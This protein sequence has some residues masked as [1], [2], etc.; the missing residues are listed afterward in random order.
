MRKDSW[1]KSMLASDLAVNLPTSVERVPVQG[2]SVPPF[3]EPIHRC[4]GREAVTIDPPRD[5]HGR[6]VYVS[7]VCAAMASKKSFH[8]R[9]HAW[10]KRSIS[11]VLAVRV[12]YALNA[13]Q[14]WR[15][16]APNAAEQDAAARE[17]LADFDALSET[18]R[19]A[20]E[21][22][23][24]DAA[25]PAMVWC[26]LQHKKGQLEAL[27]RG[28]HGVII[29]SPKACPALLRA[30]RDMGPHA[31][32]DNFYVEEVKA[33]SQMC[34]TKILPDMT[35]IDAL[36]SLCTERS[37][38][39]FS[40]CADWLFD[41][42]PACVMQHLVRD[43]P[44]LVFHVSD[45]R[46]HM[47]R[48]VA[49]FYG[50]GLEEAE[51]AE[52]GQPAFDAHYNRL[53]ACCLTHRDFDVW[54]H[55]NYGKA[56]VRM[57]A[58]AVELGINAVLVIGT[59][60]DDDK[61]RFL[62]DF[63]RECA[64]A[65]IVF[66]T[67][68]ITVGV[69]F[70]RNF[71]ACVVVEGTG[72]SGPLEAAQSS[73]RAARADVPECNF[74]LWCI[75]NAGPPKPDEK[76]TSLAAARK[77][78]ECKRV[79]KARFASR[80]SFTSEVV[81]PL[82]LEVKAV[83]EAYDID[84][85]SHCALLVQKLIEY[86]PGWTLVDP[87]AIVLPPRLAALSDADVSAALEAAKPLP[88]DQIQKVD[89]LTPEQ[90]MRLGYGE[91][92][93]MATEA[94]EGG[95][96]ESYAAAEKDVLDTCGGMFAHAH[97]SGTFQ[98]GKALSGVD[99]QTVQSWRA[100]RHF[101]SLAA[102]TPKQLL[103]VEK[104]ED[105][106]NLAACHL[107]LG[108][109]R[110]LL[111]RSL[112]KSAAADSVKV[113]L[114]TRL[115]ER[116]DALEQ[117]ST[118]IGVTCL[119]IES[120]V[121]TADAP[122]VRLLQLDKM[123]VADAEISSTRKRL[124]VLADTVAGDSSVGSTKD[125]WTTLNSLLALICAEAVVIKDR[126][127]T[128]A[129]QADWVKRNECEGGGFLASKC[130][131]TAAAT[132]ADA[133]LR[134]ILGEPSEDGSEAPTE[135]TETANDAAA[136]GVSDGASV[137]KRR[138]TVP[139][140]KPQS[141]LAREGTNLRVPVEVEL[142]RRVFYF[143]A[144]G[145]VLDPRKARCVKDGEYR[146]ANQ[147]AGEATSEALKVTPVDFVAD[148]RVF[149]A[150]L[151]ESITTRALL[152]KQMP[153][154]TVEQE[155]AAL[156]PATEPP[157][158]VT[159]E[160]KVVFAAAA[161][162]QGIK[163][164]LRVTEKDG[165]RY[166]NEPIP[167]AAFAK[168]L[169]QLREEKARHGNRLCSPQLL[170]DFKKASRGERLRLEREHEAKAQG[171][172]GPK[173]TSQLLWL[174]AVDRMAAPAA[175]GIR[176]LP[177]VY[178]KKKGFGRETASWPSLQNAEAEMRRRLMRR[179]AHDWD[180]V[181]CHCFIVEAVVRGFLELD[182]EQ[183]I[184]TLLRYNR[185]RTA[186]VLANRGSAENEFLGSIAEW[187]GVTVG[188]AK[189][190]PLV[191]LNQ[192]STTAWLKELEP[193]RA[194]PAKGNHPDLIRLQAEALG[195]RKLFFEHAATLF[196]RGAFDG[197]RERLQADCPDG[198]LDSKEKM[199]K[200][201]FSYCLMHFENVALHICTAASA[202]HGLPPLTDIYDGFLQLHVEGGDT[203]AVKRDAEAALLAHFK[204]PLYLI[205]KP[206]FQ[207]AGVDGEEDDGIDHALIAPPVP[208]T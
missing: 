51:A 38:C 149:S 6:G 50:C 17:A 48:D 152:S 91:L 114:Y 57:Y 47:K 113:G 151:G 195:V 133:V 117:A 178:Q 78:V 155:L 93:R 74:I 68:T 87:T 197:L 20:A 204:S 3:D 104:Y 141:Q 32:I 160:Q 116:I 76:L 23:G 53:L 132:E 206:F 205:E 122:F 168:E 105:E 131:D 100:A 103:V 106:L 191:L 150:E 4:E 121:L 138:K 36:G 98:H 88:L 177:V 200:T 140:S 11:A 156:M 97:I 43:R 129:E 18:D 134:Q 21:Q 34:F 58:R 164:L 95:R 170:E 25:A 136:S 158:E 22:F 146:P 172:L 126:K 60:D 13:A 188:E 154:A 80:S 67:S 85:R 42:A 112:L 39:V 137:A 81:P 54:V 72:A 44:H 29:V 115:P 15:D 109:R 64:N 135:A 157:F 33:L 159:E 162:G 45:A 111:A 120:Q 128:V 77:A 182:P 196:P 2:D 193:P 176:W 12:S 10:G 124:R 118:L 183:Y 28:G 30:V 173:R 41:P 144:E 92:V 202:K 35:A 208:S 123:G 31:R 163:R 102:F 207:A 65:Q 24:P 49:L 70:K 7:N 71:S 189:F 167:A 139:K 127:M 89:S 110:V 107:T 82:M 192:G 119:A 153:L 199:E 185:S 142:R 166:T 130:N 59:G 75:T 94:Y 63:D 16:S 79:E 186:D 190:G 184:P 40:F 145:N 83:N 26:Y 27:F 52:R 19:R 69:N 8:S 46:P 66:S 9:I 143:D 56:C 96:F 5:E 125:L 180:L 73:G 62:T 174:E 175:G 14:E 61:V 148:W 161:E 165:C 84:K 55:C 108:S 187:Y 147:K 37:R 179:V 86:K 101:P 171:L 198:T 90:K 201:L 181:S 99:K 169:K 203:A 194:V 1:R